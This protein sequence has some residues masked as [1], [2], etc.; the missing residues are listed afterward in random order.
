M[1]FVRPGGDL[2]AVRS[3]LGSF[4]F[5]VTHFVTA[6]HRTATDYYHILTRKSTQMY[7]FVLDYRGSSWKLRRAEA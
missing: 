5:P 3:F 1:R 4:A 6:P 7:G 2:I